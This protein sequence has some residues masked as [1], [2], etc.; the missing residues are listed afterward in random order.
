M[1]LL[2][3]LSEFGLSCIEAWHSDHSVKDTQICLDWAMQLCLTPSGGSDYHGMV[4]PDI[5]L[6]IGYGNLCIPLQILENIKKQRKAQ[7]LWI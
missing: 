3:E 2:K 1:E 7:G 6:G 4:K 5:S